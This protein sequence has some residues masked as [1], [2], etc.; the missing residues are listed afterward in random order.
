[1]CVLLSSRL[2]HWLVHMCGYTPPPPALLAICLR[3]SDAHICWPVL[4]DVVPIGRCCVFVV[5]IVPMK[6]VSQC[7]RWSWCWLFTCVAVDRL[8]Q[9]AFCRFERRRSDGGFVCN[10]V[11]RRACCLCATPIA[12]LSAS[13]CAIF[14]ASLLHPR[15]RAL[16]RFVLVCGGGGC[17]SRHR[18]RSRGAVALTLR[19]KAL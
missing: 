12:S 9:P 6:Q 14:A 10:V 2:K 11:L 3:T 8:C 18:F 17:R 16:Q 15:S 5:P 4:A 7:S 13:R 19:R 1:M